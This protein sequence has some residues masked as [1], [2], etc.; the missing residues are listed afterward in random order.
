MTKSNSLSIIVKEKSLVILAE[1]YALLIDKDGSWNHESDVILPTHE[2]SIDDSLQR[3]NQNQQRTRRVANW[4]MTTQPVDSLVPTLCSRI[5]RNSCNSQQFAQIVQNSSRKSHNS[6]NPVP[7]PN[8]EQNDEEWLPQSQ[9]PGMHPSQLNSYS[10]PF[11]G[12]VKSQD[13]N[14]MQNK[15]V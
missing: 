6:Q 1:K 8:D 11:L 7:D 12:L 10:N 14:N 4:E 15:S 9:E 2:Y 3:D 5:S 13:F